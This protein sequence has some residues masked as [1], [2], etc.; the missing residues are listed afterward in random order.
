MAEAVEGEAAAGQEDSASWPCR[1]A[2]PW[3]R[4]TAR[5]WASCKA[6]REEFLSGGKG[7]EAFRQIL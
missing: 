7:E 4:S 1:F 5:P 6:T 2:G 3:A